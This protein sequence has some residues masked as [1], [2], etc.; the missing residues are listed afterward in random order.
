MRTAAEY[1][2]YRKRCVKERDEFTRY[3]TRGLLEELLPIVD[4]FE[5][6]MQMAVEKFQPDK[7][8]KFFFVC[9]QDIP[10]KERVKGVWEHKNL[11]D[12]L[13]LFDTGKQHAD[14]YKSMFEGTSAIPQKAIL[15]N[16][17][18]RYRAEGYSGSPSQL[19][20]EMVAVIELLKEESK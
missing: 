2:N 18:I 17:R 9:T 15:K 1:D 6:G 20:D 8:V 13:V 4:N 10:D 16:G 19:M 14:V 11:H 3:A 12:M 5:M 7:N